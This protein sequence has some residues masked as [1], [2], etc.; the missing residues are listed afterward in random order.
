MH[1]ILVLTVLLRYRPYDIDLIML[2]HT[3]RALYSCKPKTFLETWNR[4]YVGDAQERNNVIRNFDREFD[5]T[6]CVKNNRVGFVKVLDRW[7]VI[8]TML[9]PYIYFKTGVGFC[10]FD[11]CCLSNIASIHGIIREE[12]IVRS[13]IHLNKK[14]YVHRSTFHLGYGK[15]FKDLG[16]PKILTLSGHKSWVQMSSVFPYALPCFKKKVICLG[17][18]WGDV[19]RSMNDCYLR[20]VMHAVFNCVDCRVYFDGL[21]I[22]LFKY[23]REKFKMHSCCD[24]LMDVRS[25]L[26]EK[27]KPTSDGVVLSPMLFVTK[28]YAI[29]V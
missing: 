27:V 24:R 18:R 9:V 29:G 3:C 16:Y 6:F 13:S 17:L 2:Y 26:S 22:Y 7:Y 15:C 1:T 5:G 10:V 21:M 8:P 12:H 19:L 25:V 23:D 20:R 28:Q 11:F 14:E 4:A